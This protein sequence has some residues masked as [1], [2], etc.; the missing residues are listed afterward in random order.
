LPPC[1][2]SAA[3]SSSD[4]NKRLVRRYVEEVWNCGRLEALERYVGQEYVFVPPDRTPPIRGPRGL[5]RHIAAMR[6]ALAGLS[7]RIECIVAEDERVTWSWTMTGVHSGPGLGSPTGRRIETRGV[8]IYRIVGGRIVE[9]S[10]EADVLG[11]L[12]QLGLLPPL[13]ELDGCAP[14]PRGDA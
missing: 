10:G 2:A 13:A 5:A 14:G 6:R 4:D 12:S 7:M 1:D 9:R 3:M 11:L 8:A